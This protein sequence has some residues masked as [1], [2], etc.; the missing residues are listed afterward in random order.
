MI[1][2]DR[3]TRSWAEFPNRPLIRL[4]SSAS[5]F[6]KNCLHF[7]FL[8]C[9]IDYLVD[10]QTFFRFNAKMSR[11]KNRKKSVRRLTWA[12]SSAS[13]FNG[14]VIHGC[15]DIGCKGKLCKFRVMSWNSDRVEKRGYQRL[16]SNPDRLAVLT[17]KRFN[18]IISSENHFPRTTKTD[19]ILFWLE[20][21]DQLKRTVRF[22][23]SH[24]LTR[25]RSDLGLRN[26]I[27]SP[28][29]IAF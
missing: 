10:L 9:A 12:S 6:S 15:Y 19:A 8:R 3:M 27:N 29:F 28:K 13:V 11:G 14:C 4:R 1:S 7:A 5:I 20:L 2:C 26:A 23:I 17:S 22:L 21:I 24:T 25:L 16:K 18:K